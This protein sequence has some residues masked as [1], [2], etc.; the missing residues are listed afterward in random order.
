MFALCIQYVNKIKQKVI[1]LYTHCRYC[2]VENVS[3]FN[4]KKAKIAELLKSNGFVDIFEKTIKNRT[5]GVSGKY[6]NCKAIILIVESP[7]ETEG[8]E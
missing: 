7:H 5:I 6:V 1:I 8:G 2:M 4:E 3:T